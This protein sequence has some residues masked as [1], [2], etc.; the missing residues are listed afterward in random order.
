MQQVTGRL[1]ADATVK[2]LD[3][4]RMV[5]SFHIA[6]NQDYKPKDSDQ[7]V[8]NPTF[9]SC[10]YWRGVSIVQVLRKGAE[11]LLQGQVKA[12][13]YRSQDGDIIPTLNFTARDIQLLRYAAKEEK[14]VEPATGKGKAK[15]SNK[16]Q[17]AAA[18]P[19][20]E[21]NDLPF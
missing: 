13:Y 20:A 2:T 6:E 16:K 7:W 21:T 18:A 4:G 5:V 11:V 3:N 15:K 14:A 19:V 1:T 10:S 9:F 8:K 17:T 12:N